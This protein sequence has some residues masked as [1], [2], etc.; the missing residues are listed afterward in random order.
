MLIVV[1]DADEN[2]VAGR[3]GHLNQQSQIDAHDPLVILIPR[4]HIETWIRAALGD[5][6]NENDSYKKPEPKKSEI[7]AAGIQIHG[8]ARE[9]PLPGATCV[10]SLRIALPEWRKIT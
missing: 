7:R 8:W 1:V 6:V 2:T 5:A 9:N 4:R 10:D 3:R